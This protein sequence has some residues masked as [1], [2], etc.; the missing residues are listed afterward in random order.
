[1]VFRRICMTLLA[2]GLA[3]GCA[4]LPTDPD[5]RAEAE[6]TNDPLEPTNRVIYDV[7]ISL[8]ETVMAPVAE[9]Y[10]DV[11]P[12][13]FREAVHNMLANLQ[14][15]YTAGNDLLQGNTRAAADALG[16]FF[17]NT[18]FGVLGTRD[19]IAETG[20][21]RLH[22]T[23]IGV[24][25]AVW[26]VDDGP[27]LMLPL[28]GPSGVRDGTGKIAEFWAS[29]TGAVLGAYDLSVVSNVQTGVDL[30]D[31]RTA[32]IDP[33]KE[34]RRTTL[35]E[36][37][38]VRS[39]YRQSRAAAIAQARAGQ[40]QSRAT[41]E[42]GASAAPQAGGGAPGGTAPD[43]TVVEHPTAVEFIEPRP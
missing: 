23:D 6:A 18:T 22:K 31:T 9:T 35:D 16:R 28:F 7:N 17:I 19:A 26:G 37:A 2:A 27:Y 10:R 13:W 30:L 11:M 3:A 29:P 41:T 34:L 4:Q 20:G 38:A 32:L 24:T 43:G 14:E 5:E 39:L 21:P 36:Y 40:P 12:D 15:P 8:D 42:H 33:M 1:M 25:L